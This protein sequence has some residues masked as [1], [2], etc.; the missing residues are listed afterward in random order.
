MSMFEETIIIK[1]YGEKLNS[2]NPRRRYW[3]IFTIPNVDTKTFCDILLETEVKIENWIPPFPNEDLWFNVKPCKYC[4]MMFE[5]KWKHMSAMDS[6]FWQ[7]CHRHRIVSMLNEYNIIDNK[8]RLIIIKPQFVY[9][10]TCSNKH[11]LALVLT[12]QYVKANIDGKVFTYK[13]HINSYPFRSTYSEIAYLVCQKIR[14]I[15]KIIEGEVEID[16]NIVL[17]NEIIHNVN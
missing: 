8:L 9:H 3:Y 2:S 13:N 16:T 5:R 6:W 17:N 4:K 1:T 11:S 10:Y 15:R 14:T 12:K 7:Y